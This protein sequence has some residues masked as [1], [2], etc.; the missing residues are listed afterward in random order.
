MR[1]ALILGFFVTLFALTTGTLINTA[2]AQEAVTS[3]ENNPEVRIVKAR[4]Q[5]MG[6]LLKTTFGHSTVDLSTEHIT[7]HISEEVTALK[8]AITEKKHK[9]SSEDQLFREYMESALAAVKNVHSAY[10]PISSYRRE[11]V[12]N[13][14][15]S[16]YHLTY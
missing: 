14:V 15:A 8:K 1:L 12:L 2:S 10:L 4:Q 9:M 11:R 5:I 13:I 6:K 3:N 16:Y 7:R